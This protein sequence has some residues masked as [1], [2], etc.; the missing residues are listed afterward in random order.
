MSNQSDSTDQPG[1][2]ALPAKPPQT[3]HTGLSFKPRNVATARPA[4]QPAPV[5]NAS[6]YPQNA[7]GYGGYQG[8][9]QSYPQQAGQYGGGDYHYGAYDAELDYQAQMHQWQAN[10]G[11]PGKTPGNANNTPLENNRLWSAKVEVRSGMIR[12]CWSGATR[13]ACLSAI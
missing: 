1:K 2:H 3:Q 6:A 7:G 5:V 10:Y 4:A 9:D 12:L 8:Y 13:I 11:N